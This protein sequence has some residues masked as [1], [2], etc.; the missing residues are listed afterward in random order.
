MT[1]QTFLTRALI[2]APLTLGSLAGLMATDLVLPA[3]PEFPELLETTPARAQLVLASFIGGIM[4]GLLIFGGLATRFNRAAFL[5]FGFVGFGVSSWVCGQLTTIEPLIA[6]RFVQGMFAAVPALIAPG[7][8]RQIFSEVG[9]TRALGAL[10]SLEALAPAIGPIIGAWLL[11]LGGWTLSFDV[12]AVISLVL[13][14]L[15][16]L[17]A[18][19]I[20]KQ[21]ESARS[22]R[23]LSLLSSP[24]YLRYALSQAFVLGG[25]LI[26]VLAA[27]AM[28][29]YALGGTLNDFIAMQVTGVACFMVASNVTGFFVKRFGAESMIWFGSAMCTVSAVGLLGLALVPEVDPIWVVILFAPFNAGLGFRGPPGFLRAVIAGAGNDERAA[30]LM[31]LAI[32]AVTSIGTA[33]LAGV[34]EQGLFYVCLVVVALEVSALLL[35]WRLPR[36]SLPD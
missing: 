9:A 33:A 20:P 7:V 12:L 26:F 17:V 14:G 11:A 3:V 5:I 8:I 15:T 28:I 21:E 2:L 24:V 31:I 18:R 1:T 10:G 16:F 29:Q 19:S 34:V 22:G 27:P 30:S 32:F 6:M 35:L 25:M 36:L 13:A 23:Y 4:G